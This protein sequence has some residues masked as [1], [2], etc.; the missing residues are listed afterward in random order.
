MTQR[1]ER[2]G[3]VQ[4]PP[5]VEESPA[6]SPGRTMMYPE[7]VLK[8][9][10]RQ[11]MSPRSVQETTHTEQ[12]AEGTTGTAGAGIVWTAMSSFPSQWL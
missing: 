8:S 5:G 3:T 12:T 6:T 11:S 10:T 7:T 1:R 2:L 9:G 4:D